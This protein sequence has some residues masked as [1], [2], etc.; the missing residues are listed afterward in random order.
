MTCFD[1]SMSSNSDDYYI[2]L[3]DDNELFNSF[4]EQNESTISVNNNNG[5]ECEIG[6]LE[7]M[8]QCILLVN[9]DLNK[10]SVHQL[11]T[12]NQEIKMFKIGKKKRNHK[13]IIP[14]DD[15]EELFRKDYYYAINKGIRKRVRKELIVQYHKMIR[16]K[17]TSIRKMARY[18][19]RSINKYFID[20][21]DQKNLIIKAINELIGD[22]CINYDEDHKRLNLKS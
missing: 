11:S 3:F 4:N 16:K 5:M 10:S 9:D 1:H 19:R 17:Y 14:L 21:L 15:D 22:G 12:F 18:E 20:F 13:E 8:Q 6:N 7:N 2:D